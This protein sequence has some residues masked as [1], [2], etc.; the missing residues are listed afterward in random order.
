MK[1]HGGPNLARGPEFD[2]HVLEES[3]YNIHNILYTDKS[4]LNTYTLITFLRLKDLL[5]NSLDCL[6]SRVLL[7]YKTR[8]YA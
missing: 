1:L 3:L 7:P 8:A 4:H 5:L 2:T 6:N